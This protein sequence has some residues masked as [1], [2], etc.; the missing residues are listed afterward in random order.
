MM[1]KKTILI[2]VVIGVFSLLSYLGYNVISKFKEKNQIAK[3]LE[4]IPEFEFLTLEQKQFTKANLN[5]NTNTIF[6]YFNS[7]CDF[8]QHEAQS[9]ND[10]LEKFKNVQFIFVS[11]EPI[12]IIKKFAEQYN[13]NNQPNITF[14]YDNLDT[15]SSRFDANSI[16]YILIYNK[17]QKLIKKNK[18]Q[19]N[20]KG[21]LRA[22]QQ[23]D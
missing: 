22:L 13:L 19:L 7:E 21:I 17:S 11:A 18:G 4:V 9:I 16:P 8:C 5:R 10:N 20:A 3:Q 23:N 14:L 2:I 6:I 15:F 1:K 12:E